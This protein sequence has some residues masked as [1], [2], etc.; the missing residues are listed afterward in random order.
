MSFRVSPKMWPV[1]ALASPVL[2]PWLVSKS[3]RFARGRAAAEKQNAERLAAA[4]PLEL[5]RLERLEITPLVEQFAEPGFEGDSG[6]S[7][8]IETELGALVMDVGYGPANGVLTHNAARLGRTLDDAQA[9][10]ISHLHL[11]HM[12]GLE[13][14]RNRKVALPPEFAAAEPKPCYLPDEADCQGLRAIRVVEPRLIEA[15]L[16]TT[17]PLAR[18]LYFFGLTQEQALLGWLEGKGIAVITGC[19]HPT[20]QT[21][22]AMVER[23]TSEPIYAVV[24]GLHF[25]VT[26]SRSVRNGLAAQ[27]LFGTGKG[28]LSP[29]NDDDLSRAVEALN[30]AGVKRLLISAHDSCDHA[31]TR[32]EAELDGRVEALKAGA[33]YRL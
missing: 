3:L 4:R 26:A 30:E 18:M 11:D 6:V 9:L 17:G 33:T 20:I 14:Q 5:P 10:V 28:L 13:G 25:P 16:A 12:G 24:G 1:L 23:L 21:I 29:I 2:I 31:L 27:R 8:F 7:Y 22:L 19:G 15:G 32:F